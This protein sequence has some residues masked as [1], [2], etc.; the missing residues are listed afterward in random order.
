MMNLN[1]LLDFIP[2]QIFKIALNTSS[3]ILTYET[4]TYKPPKCT[5]VNRIDKMVTFKSKTEYVLE[6]VTPK[7][8]KKL[9]SKEKI[10]NNKKRKMVK[11]CLI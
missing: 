10:S 8:M 9:R 1:S 3:K 5:Y 11:M 2:W 4:L 6:P 7:T